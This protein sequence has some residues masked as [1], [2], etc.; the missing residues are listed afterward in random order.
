L[1]VEEALNASSAIGDDR[2]QKQTPGHIIPESFTHGT[3]KQRVH[4]FTKGFETGA[5]D[6]CNTFEAGGF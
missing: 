3:S 6:Q 2:L 4:W 1:D 5:V